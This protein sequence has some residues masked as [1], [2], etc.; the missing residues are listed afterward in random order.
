MLHYSLRP[1]GRDLSLL[2]NSTRRI[3]EQLTVHAARR[4][5]AHVLQCFPASLH[6]FPVREPAIN[7]TKYQALVLVHDEQKTSLCV[8]DLTSSQDRN[9]L[10]RRALLESAEGN[11]R[12]LKKGTIDPGECEECRKIGAIRD[13]G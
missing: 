9:T 1:S 7:T 3:Q 10:R 12:N 6:V 11:L 4:G 2:A 5:R 13:L 8:L